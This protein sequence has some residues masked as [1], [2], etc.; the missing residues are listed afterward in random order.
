MI[1]ARQW[2]KRLHQETKS[3]IERDPDI[4]TGFIIRTEEVVREIQLDA[5]SQCM[6]LTQQLMDVAPRPHPIG[7][8][9]VL[10]RI[11]DL[12]LDVKQRVTPKPGDG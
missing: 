4:G 8:G 3:S 1:D 9:L 7:M 5:I 12:A 2:A 6:R 10:D 11:S